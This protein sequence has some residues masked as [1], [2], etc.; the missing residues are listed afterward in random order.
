MVP[1][2]RPGGL[3]QEA[4]DDAVLE[5]VEA[6]H[7]EPSA[8]AQQHFGRAQA[9]LELVELGVDVDADRLEAARRGIL[10]RAR[11]GSRAPCAP[12]GRDRRWS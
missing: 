1:R 11:R 2:G 12:R 3:A 5:A 4:L 6:D 8:F 9:G 10:R 7:R